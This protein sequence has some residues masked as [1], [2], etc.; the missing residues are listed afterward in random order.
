MGRVCRLAAV[1]PVTTAW[2]ADPSVDQILG[3]AGG[4]L[5]G[6][7]L[8]RL[9]AEYGNDSMGETAEN[10]YELTRTITRVAQDAI[11]YEFTVED[12]KALLGKWRV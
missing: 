11:H 10:V 1:M 4:S 8:S 5:P 3:R 9:K 6:F 12:A 2:A 7:V